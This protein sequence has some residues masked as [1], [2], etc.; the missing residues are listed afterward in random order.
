MKKLRSGRSRPGRRTPGSCWRRGGLGRA[1]GLP[2]NWR[3]SDEVKRFTLWEFYRNSSLRVLVPHLKWIYI[4]FVNFPTP[5]LTNAHRFAH[6]LWQSFEMI[7]STSCF[8]TWVRV[9]VGSRTSSNANAFSGLVFLR[10]TSV[11]SFFKLIM[12]ELIRILFS[13]LLRCLPRV[14]VENEN[15]MK[16]FWAISK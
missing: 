8:R 6:R 7:T 12:Y 9:L 10:G 13:A 15:K 2:G 14:C 1:T 11:R 4:F 5:A 16:H 3:I